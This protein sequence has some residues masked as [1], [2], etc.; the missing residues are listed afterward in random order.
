MTTEL[1]AELLGIYRHEY[2]SQTALPTP[3]GHRLTERDR[4][5][6]QWVEDHFGEE[7]AREFE[8]WIGV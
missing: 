4:E 2:R 8:A 5:Y 6:W 3:R 1:F 7:T